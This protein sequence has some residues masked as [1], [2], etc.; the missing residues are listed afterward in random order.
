M[1]VGSV[2]IPIPKWGFLRECRCLMAVCHKSLCRVAG[3]LISIHL[4][5]DTV[6]SAEGTL[7]P[8]SDPRY[9]GGVINGER[10]RAASGAINL[11]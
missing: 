4:G 1:R 2:A 10:T 3:T 7:V 11:I 5:G 6:L 9:C 8:D